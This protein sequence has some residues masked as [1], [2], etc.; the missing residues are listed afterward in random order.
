ML[1]LND[2]TRLITD[3]P[4]H[5]LR[6]QAPIKVFTIHKEALVE[7]TNAVN[8]DSSNEHARAAHRVDFDGPVRVNVG[9]VV[10]TEAWTLGEQPTET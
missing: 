8:D 9:Q 1:M 3:G 6:A 4:T 10:P 2:D 7:Q 5:Q